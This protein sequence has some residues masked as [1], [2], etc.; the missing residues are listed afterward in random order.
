M[1]I[2]E[3]IAYALLHGKK[4]TKKELKELFW[5][6]SSERGRDSNMSNLCL[7]H[8]KKIDPAWINIMVE[9]CGVDANFL[10]GVE[11]MKTE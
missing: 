7:G 5:P 1:K 11:P 8:T 3:A 2:D 9:R 4:I 6:D 10:F